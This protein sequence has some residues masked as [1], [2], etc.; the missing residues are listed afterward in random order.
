[1]IDVLRVRGGSIIGRDHMLNQ[2]N[3]QDAFAIREEPGMVAAFVC[4]GCGSSEHSEVGAALAAPFLAYYGLDL[5]RTKERSLQKCVHL[6]DQHLTNY[7]WRTLFSQPNNTIDFVE[8]YLLFTIVGVLVRESEAILL[9]VGDGIINND[10]SVFRI[11]QDNRP[12][13][14]SYNLLGH[15]EDRNEFDTWAVSTDWKRLAIATDGFEPNL[16]P[17]L[18]VSELNRP[19]SLQRKLNKW[20]NMDRRFNDDATVVIVDRLSEVND[21]GQD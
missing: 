3:R 2:K 8:R 7:L 9:S 14:F 10:S 18:P 5:L 4:D 16:F 1:M 15:R 6:L 13:Y 11:D 21:A 12:R 20:S 19:N 17:E